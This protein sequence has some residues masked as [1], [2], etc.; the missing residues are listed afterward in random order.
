MN[1]EP[2]TRP[3]RETYLFA[4]LLFTAWILTWL[5][6][7]NLRARPGWNTDIDTIFWIIMKF[8]IWVVPVILVIRLFDR[9]PVGRFLELRDPGRG[10][11]W[12]VGVGAALVAITFLGRTLPSGAALR[13]SLPAWPFVNAVLIAPI[14]EEITLRGF[15]LKRLRLSDRSFWAANVLTTV[16]FIVMHLPGWYFQSRFSGMG[17][18]VAGALPI[19][20]LSLLFGWTMKRSGSLVAPIVLHAI[21]NCY[22]VLVR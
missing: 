5:V 15:V 21:N 14:V 19:A 6:D 20:G 2:V 1:D 17:A 22:S 10:L 12:G 18:L 9:A 13:P 7:L 11:L 8:V 4:L 3:E 16:F